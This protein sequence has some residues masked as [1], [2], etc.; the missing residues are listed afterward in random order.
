MS[1]TTDDRYLEWLYELV[2]A[3]GNRNPDRTYWHL[4]TQLYSK[5]FVWL[6][7]NDDNRVEDGKELRHEFVNEQGSDGIDPAWM[8]L[9]CSVLEMLVALSRRASF[10]TG[11]RPDRW[12]WLMVKNMGLSGYWD[13]R[14]SDAIFEAVDQAMEQLIFRTYDRT[15]KGGLF[16]LKHSPNDQREVEIWYQLAEYL[17]EGYPI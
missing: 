5:E 15:G 6:V 8:D 10:E 16:P 14:Y 1:G 12:F 3:A 2:A 13:A 11:M 9:G 4:F 17:L 7:A